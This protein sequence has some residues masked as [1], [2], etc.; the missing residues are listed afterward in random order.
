[1]PLL[2]RDW[3]AAVDAGLTAIVREPA[4]DLPRA[5]RALRRKLKGKKK[6]E[7][8]HCAR[9]LAAVRDRVAKLSW[10]SEMTA[11]CVIRRPVTKL[12]DIDYDRCL[13]T[14]AKEF[15][16]VARK[17]LGRVQM[18]SIYWYYLK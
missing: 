5:V 3:I 2:K 18:E 13:D 11:P 8:E 15:P 6:E 10:A 4:L 7:L 17:A 16:E 1:M 12:D 14:I 9:V